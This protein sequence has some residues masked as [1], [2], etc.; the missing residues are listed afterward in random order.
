MVKFIRQEQKW[1]V[2]KSFPNLL[3]FKK[4]L[5]FKFG[6]DYTLWVVSSFNNTLITLFHHPTKK[7]VFVTSCGVLGIV[8]SKKATPFAAEQ[9]GEKVGLRLKQIGISFI[10]VNLKGL[11]SGKVGAVKG[12]AKVGIDIISIV[13]STKVA[14]GGTKAKKIRRV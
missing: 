6:S 3:P 2:I 9:L 12:L 11:G 8:G 1:K 10:C 7:P 14:F 5:D 4:I 13:E